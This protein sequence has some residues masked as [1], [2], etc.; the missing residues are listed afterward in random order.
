[1][2]AVVAMVTDRAYVLAFLASFLL[3]SGAEREGRRTAFWLASGTVI[4]WLAEAV[5]IR[6]GFPFGWYTYHPESFPREA[7]FSGVPLFASLSF[8]FL[9]Y[10]GFSAAYTL[11]SPLRGRGAALARVEDPARARSGSVL[12]LAAVLTTWADTLTDPV[13]HLGRYWFLGDL[14]EYHADGVHFHVPLSNYLGWLLTSA[15]IVFAN[16]RFDAWL[17]AREASFPPGLTLPAKPLWAL[18]S[19]V[20]NAA[21][22]IGITL[23]L[24]ASPEVP[25]HVPLRGILISGLLL[26]AVFLLAAG[27]LLRRG[28]SRAA[29][30]A[31]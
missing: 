7:W 21:F 12:V 11:L 20:G 10:F 26:T 28:M 27:V 2:D 9:S 16:Q 18:G 22:M 1:M 23:Y 29:S 6:T 24:L 17:S 15:C 13:A 4:G 30:A 25:E 5:S 19:L 8:A 31:A 3:V 14:Y